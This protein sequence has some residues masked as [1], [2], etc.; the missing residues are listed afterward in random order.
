MIY[1]DKGNL[2]KAN[3]EGEQ[4]KLEKKVH[5]VSKPGSKLKVIDEIRFN[6]HG[7]P[8]NE[9]TIVVL[10][11]NLNIKE[12]D[13]HRSTR[14]EFGDICLDFAITRNILSYSCIRCRYF[15]RK[16]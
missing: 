16:K 5:N 12:V 11:R 14:C 3:K 9:A 2:H 10:N 13:E 7:N 15:S 8:K 4:N 1:F 6:P